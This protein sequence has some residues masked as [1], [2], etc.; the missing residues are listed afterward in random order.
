[1]SVPFIL[2][3]PIRAAESFVKVRVEFLIGGDA[4]TKCILGSASHAGGGGEGGGGGG[5]EG[6]RQEVRCRQGRN[7]EGDPCLPL[8]GQFRSQAACF[9][10]VAESPHGRR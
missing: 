8:R 4:S 6:E 1:M 10:A 3:Q 7:S 5:E 9:T 2:N